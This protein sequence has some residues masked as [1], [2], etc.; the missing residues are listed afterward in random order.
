MRLF[1]SLVRRNSL[2]L[3]LMALTATAFATTLWSTLRPKGTVMQQ[4]LQSLLKG[5]EAGVPVSVMPDGLHPN[6]QGYQIWAD[7]IIDTV[8]ELME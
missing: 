5:P 1:S 3:G 6:T 8:H 2:L 7:A 4:R